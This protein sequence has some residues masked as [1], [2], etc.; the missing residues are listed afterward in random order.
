MASQQ[1][2]YVPEQSK[3]P[4]I[5]T[6]GLFFTMVGA[7]TAINAISA[8]TDTSTGWWMFTI[9]MAVM[10]YMLFGWFGNVAKESMAGLYSPQMDRS[11]RWGMSWFIFS[12]VMFFGAFFGALF[13][14]RTLSV[15]WLAG[16]GA[17]AANELLWPN[18]E[19]TWPLMTNPNPDTFPGPNSVIS[20]WDIPLINTFLLLASSVTITIAHHAI[21]KDER[22][23]VVIWTGLTVLLGVIFM[24][25]QIHEY[26]VAYN[27]LDLT[28]DS[29]IYGTTFFMLTG[30]HGMHVTL[31]AIIIFII[32]IRY[33][34]G[35]FSA[36]QHFG[37]EAAAWY[38]HFVD[39]VWVCLFVFVY[40]I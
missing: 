3:W 30:F 7:A 2:Y 1:S 36:E 18:F 24:G 39:V 28:L 5:A 4:I 25:F 16:E 21:K 38:W 31:G 9:G 12:E 26:D 11:F 27:Q 37:F 8:G 23:K 40:V 33:M 13:Y 34:K 29:G 17:G 35:H 19:N 10:V 20:A 15:P 32:L 14:A 22:Q 6:I